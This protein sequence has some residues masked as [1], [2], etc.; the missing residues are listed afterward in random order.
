MINPN[1]YPTPRRAWL[2]VFILLLAYVLSFMDRQIVYLLVAPI[3][4]DMVLTDTKISLLMGL[5]FAIFYAIAGIPLGRVVDTKS[6]RG[7]I[8]C[9]VLFW[10]LMTA[11]CGLAKVYWQLLLMR[12]GTGAGEATLSPAAYSILADSFPP[13]KR[14]TAISV[15]GIGVYIGIGMAYLLGGAIITWANARGDVILPLFGHI[16]PWQVIFLV[17]GALGILFAL[18]LLAI[19]E[20]T[21]KGAG[22][23][24]VVP[25]KDV[26][27]YIVGLRK[28]VL[29]HNRGFGCLVFAASGV[30][31]WTPTFLLR[32]HG[33]TL[34]K[35]GLYVGSISIVAGSLGVM[36][37]GRLADYLARRGFRDSNMRVGL[38]GG[39]LTALGGV[40]YLIDN[41][42]LLWI[43]MFVY[44]FAAA[45]PNGVAAAA[46]Q[47]IMP[48]SM[49][50]QTSA[51]YLLAVTLIGLG[52]GPTAVAL[53]T[54]YVFRDDMAV[55]NS[56]VWV[57]SIASGLGALLIWSGLKPYAQAR[58]TLED[59]G[60]QH[61]NSDGLI[62]AP[63]EGTTLQRASL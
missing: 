53:V 47:E 62:P 37:G 34:G 46:I 35:V 8:F 43:F 40:G 6:R 9:G 58:Q 31:A 61:G 38:L 21:R 14:A 22:A 39:V 18:P 54:D 11:S 23:G 13:Q 10:S 44:T 36:S 26:G 19:K 5:S 29:S 7:L 42:T 20:P 1:A 56:I 59:W 17:L 60:A 2:T 4:R 25:L 48:N 27:R 30:G 49:R 12:V 41:L 15:Y 33:M 45:M 51:I 32:D 3:R 28:A 16:K 63:H 52:L 55:R 57:G 24:V 50:G